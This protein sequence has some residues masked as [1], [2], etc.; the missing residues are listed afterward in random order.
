MPGWLVALVRGGAR[1]L[2]P[3]RTDCGGMCVSVTGRGPQGWV[4]RRWM[5]VVRR[6]EGPFIPGL[7]VRTILRN[8]GLV[9]PGA[10]PALAVLP[11]AQ[12]QDAMSDLAVDI[13][14][15]EE[16]LP[17]LFRRILG[18]GFDALPPAVRATHDHAGVRRW[19]GRAVVTRGTGRFAKVLA[20]L[21]RFPVA[22]QDI[23]V[24]VL[25]T[26]AGTGEDWHRQFG[27]SGFRSSLRTG[28]AGLTERFGPLT[29]ALDLTLRDGALH[30]TVRSGWCLGLPLP[31]ALLPDTRALETGPD[32]R[33]RFDVALIAP[34]RGGLIVRYQGFLVPGPTADL[35]TDASDV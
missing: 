1:L 27:T 33:F 11:L 23:P 15:T 22:G 24:T 6:G 19:T 4:R 8:P 3:F 13:R 35:S 2:A 31:R 10:G 34:L 25:K 18:P 29:F 14:R 26:P 16:P 17:P 20:A 30:Y 9:A 32:G 28:P 21:F 7:I 5:L 12:A